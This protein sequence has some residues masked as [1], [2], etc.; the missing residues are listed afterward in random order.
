[1][2]L[3]KPLC[4]A[5]LVVAG[6]APASAATIIINDAFDGYANQAAFE[7]VWTPSGASGNLTSAQSVSAPNSIGTT[8]GGTQL[9]I[10]TFSAGV[11][12]DIVATDANPLVW[13][14]MFYDDPA[15][16]PVA[17]NTLGRSYGQLH[18]RRASDGALNQLL[19][20]G[21]W[22]AVIP[23]A[24]DGV[25]S[26]TAELRQYYAVRTPSRPAGTGSC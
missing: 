8:A 26:T 7:A 14:Y 1:M 21:L 16:L 17:G 3:F 22:N 2:R 12:T 19:A 6:A 10:R 25:T 4:A 13:S 11:G 9:N 18:G 24:S 15:N 20:M 23:K 5:A